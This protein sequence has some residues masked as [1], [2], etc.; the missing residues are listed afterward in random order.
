MR[1]LHRTGL[2]F[3]ILAALLVATLPVAAIANQV[4]DNQTV[5]EGVLPV[6]F[7]TF[8]ESNEQLG[9][10]ALLAESLREFGGAYAEA[11]CWVFVP[12]TF[13]DADPEL[14]ERL[15][16]LRVELHA[17]HTPESART[18]YFSGKVFA[19]ALAE[20]KATNVSA[21]LVWMD[22]DTIILREPVAF[23]LAD[24]LAF[25]Y[26]PVMHNRSGTLYAEP[27]NKFWSRIYA[28]LKVGDDR[29]F[30]MVTPADQETIRAYFNAG[31]LVVRP[32]RGIFRTWADDFVALY[33]DSLLARMCREDT[34][35]R[36]FL[37]QTALVGAVLNRVR[38]ES[39]GRTSRRI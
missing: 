33:S 10:V 25:A 32:E 12:G 36:I 37:H 34:E 28:V 3:L 17:S 23:D 21:V 8:A 30:P 15:K 14:I 20:T 22:E 9:H 29:L 31:L 4:S 6:I 16:S 24:D 11:T 27:P 38:S 1:R 5:G 18:Y 7:A 35:K 13:S 2:D 19:A 39:D 26:R